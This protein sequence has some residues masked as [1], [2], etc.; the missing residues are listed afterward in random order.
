MQ[1]AS[2]ASIA[3]YNFFPLGPER[4]GLLLALI[5]VLAAATW[6]YLE[7]PIRGRAVLESDA[8]FLGVAGAAALAVGALGALLSQLADRA[9]RSDADRGTVISTMDRLRSDAV[10]CAGRVTSVDEASRS[11]VG[12]G[13]LSVDGRVIYGMK[14]FALRRV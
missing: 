11:L 14:G 13:F 4:L 9:E 5:F 1:S 6:R 12:E 8:R 7:A 3:Y 10:A 2:S